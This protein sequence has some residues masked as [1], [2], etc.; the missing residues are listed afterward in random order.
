MGVKLYE[1]LPGSQVLSAGFCTKISFSVVLIFS[2]DLRKGEIPEKTVS[3]CDI[4][5]NPSLLSRLIIIIVV[6]TMIIY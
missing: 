3:S 4:L 2:F 5:Q 1:M 6:V